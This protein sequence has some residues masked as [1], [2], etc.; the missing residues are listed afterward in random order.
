MSPSEKV[1]FEF[2]ILGDIPQLRSLTPVGHTGGAATL[3]LMLSTIFHL[4]HGWTE[5]AIGQEHR[6]PVERLTAHVLHIHRTPYDPQV[7]SVNRA[8]FS[9]QLLLFFVFIIIFVWGAS[10][11]FTV[12]WFCRFGFNLGLAQLLFTRSSRTRSW[13]RAIVA[14]ANGH[15]VQLP[16]GEW[17][18][19][20]AIEFWLGALQVVLSSNHDK[21]RVYETYILTLLWRA[22]HCVMSAL[23]ILDLWTNNHTKH[24][25]KAMEGYIKIPQKHLQRWQEPGIMISKNF[26]LRELQLYHNHFCIAAHSLNAIIG[27]CKCSWCHGSWTEC[28]RS[29]CITKSIVGILVELCGND[30]QGGRHDSWI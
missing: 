19:A 29:F 6:S 18:E 27:C 10:I 4:L 11:I 5:L 3:E 17:R 12:G 14:Q 21:R 15:N 26:P 1:D 23:N 2:R 9:E 7:A 13:D 8:K 28:T 25:S 16:N 22:D 20:F 30:G 24:R